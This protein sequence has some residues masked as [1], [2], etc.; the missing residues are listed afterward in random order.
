MT[1][2]TSTTFSMTG[3]QIVNAALRKLSVLGDG[4]S[5]SAT[6]L[7]AGTEALNAMLKTFMADGMPLW[8]ITEYSFS[9]TASLTY[10][11]GIGQTFNIPAPL[12]VTQCFLRRNDLTSTR[13][14]ESRNHYDYN[15]L[16]SFTTA[17]VPNTFWYEPLNQ[18]GI[19]HVWPLPDDDTIANQKLYMVYQRPYYDQISGS[20]TLDFPQW[21]HEAII[22]GLAWRLS[23]E[24]G[25]PIAD[26]QILKQDAEFFHTAALSFGTEE[27]SLYLMPD[28]VAQ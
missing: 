8:A 13:P 22:Y 18:T 10:A 9:P 4:Q 11:F 19:L 3:D 25:L 12:K 16:N 23:P 17:G 20:D 2:S 7:L 6:Q 1:T 14:L 15:L 27:D 5:P 28:W 21:W 24:Y 26:R